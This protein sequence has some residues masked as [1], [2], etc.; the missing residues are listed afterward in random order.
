M[1]YLLDRSI[2]RCKLFPSS[3]FNNSCLLIIDKAW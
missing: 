3:K 2:S 1:D